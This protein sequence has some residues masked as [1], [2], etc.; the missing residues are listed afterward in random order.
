MSWSPDGQFLFLANGYNLTVGKPTIPVVQRNAW[1]APA[2]TMSGHR[3]SIR[4]VRANPQLF[5]PDGEKDEACVVFAAGS[6]DKGFSVWRSKLPAPLQ[7][8]SLL[9]LAGLH[10]IAPGCAGKAYPCRCMRLGCPR[11]CCY[12][13][14]LHQRITS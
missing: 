7:A 1:S 9:A 14:A 5:V 12:R 13:H 2:F 4:A 3:S 10:V 6:G 8:S 11:S